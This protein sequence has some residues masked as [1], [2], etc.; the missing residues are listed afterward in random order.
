MRYEKTFW[1]P[2]ACIEPCSA[3]SALRENVSQ[4]SGWVGGT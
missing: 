2:E 3:L 1:Q 4:G